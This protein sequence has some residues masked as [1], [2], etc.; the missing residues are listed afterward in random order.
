V[1]QEERSVFWEVIVSVILKQESNMFMYPIANGFRDRATLLYSILYRNVKMH[2]NVRHAM[3]SHRLQSAL[4]LTVVFSQMYYTTWTVPAWSLERYVP[5]LESIRNISFLTIF[6]LYSERVISETVRNR[7]HVHIQFLLQMTDTK[8][9]KNTDL[10]S[11]DSLYT[12]C[13]IFFGY[14]LQV[15]AII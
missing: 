10:S 9:T 4:M 12:V 1:T 2:S 13:L 7:T 8:T 11:R 3:S 14:F 5:V 6:G 15:I